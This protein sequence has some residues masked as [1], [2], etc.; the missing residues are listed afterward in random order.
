MDSFFRSL[1]TGKVW[2]TSIL[3]LALSATVV[4][5]GDSGQL[6]EPIEVLVKKS[7][8][9]YRF[10]SVELAVSNFVLHAQEATGN[11]EIKVA[12]AP[13]KNDRGRIHFNIQM[14][15]EELKREGGVIEGVCFSATKSDSS[16]A[17]IC[18]IEPQQ[19]DP[20]GG[21]IL[22]KVKTSKRELTFDSEYVIVGASG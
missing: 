10:Y 18:R 20:V 2:V 1:T 11:Y 19:R 15:I 13:W 7:S 5:R 14:P 3:T 4:V 6:S 9:D 16:Y 17:V 12:G 8:L 21:D 22:F